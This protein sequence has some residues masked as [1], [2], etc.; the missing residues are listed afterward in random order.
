MPDLIAELVKQK[1]TYPEWVTAEDVTVRLE[2]RH[3]VFSAVAINIWDASK[4][5][6][7]F[8]LPKDIDRWPVESH[9]EIVSAMWL[10]LGEGEEYDDVPQGWGVLTFDGK[11]FETTKKP[12]F[13][14]ATVRQDLMVAMFYSLGK[15]IHAEDLVPPPEKGSVGLIELDHG[16]AATSVDGE[17]FEQVAKRARA[18]GCGQFVH[19]GKVYRVRS[20][21]ERV[22]MVVS[23]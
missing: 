16:L 13:S 8:L 1:F 6:H 17:S 4:S 10:V 7:G 23:E 5:F 2:D 21:F 18:Q 11:N 9:R 12:A 20:E 14:S 19:E 15:Q 22:G 3:C